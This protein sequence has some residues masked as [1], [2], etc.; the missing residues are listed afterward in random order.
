MCILFITTEHPDYRLIALSNRDEDFRRAT[1]PAAWTN[2]VLSPKDLAKAEHGTWFA[3]SKSGRI[4]VLLNVSENPTYNGTVSRGVFAT[5]YVTSDE[6]DMEK[7]FNQ[8]TDAA[9]KSAGFN[10][11]C[12]DFTD[13]SSLAIATNRG[14]R[15]IEHLGS[16]TFCISNAVRGIDWPKTTLGEKLLKNLLK[17]KNEDQIIKSGFDILSANAFTE[18]ELANPKSEYLQKS[19]FVPRV[20][21]GDEDYGTR[22]QTVFLVDNEGHAQY[23]EKDVL[24]GAETIFRFDVASDK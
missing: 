18:A 22:T 21:L 11:V 6:P 9:G 15:P 20:I 16:G 12:G 14:G 19:I 23:I 7:W 10:L 17:V 5:D 2:N 13:R 1:A 8:L 3:V 4:S 24:S